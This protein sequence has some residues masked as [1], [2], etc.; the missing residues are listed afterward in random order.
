MKCSKCQTTFD[1]DAKF[2]KECGESRPAVLEPTQVRDSQMTF[3]GDFSGLKR[4]GNWF[5]K[6]KSAIIIGAAAV[7][8][9]AILSS[10]SRGI[11][12]SVD[13]SP[14][15]SPESLVLTALEVL[16]D[17]GV[18]KYTKELCP[19]IKNGERIPLDRFLDD[20]N[21][22][23]PSLSK[24]TKDAWAAAD[25]K[26]ENSSWFGGTTYSQDL[27][28]AIK[29]EIAQG[30]DPILSQD[31]SADE[32]AHYWKK[33]DV[34]FE[35]FFE[36]MTDTCKWGSTVK[37]IASYDAKLA[38]VDDL[39]KSIPWYPKGFKETGFEGFAY[40]NISNQGCTYSFGSCAKFKIVSRTD[41]PTNLYVRTNHLVNGEV[42]DWSN[43]TATVAAGQVAI[44]ETSFSS[45]YSGS[46]QFVEINCY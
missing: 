11:S 15:A 19:L 2:C 44:M 39:S 31:L 25:W 9:I 28:T 38:K 32:Y 13:A 45:D 36:R 27:K 17:E 12:S 23:T 30:L 34:W 41:C 35:F 21:T 5:T 24:A 16:G 46:W 6:N 7:A 8:V 43:D 10:T 18:D 1:V 3:D 20:V 14:S 26:K 37:K 40:K 4:Q 22:N 33:K 42:D 29:F